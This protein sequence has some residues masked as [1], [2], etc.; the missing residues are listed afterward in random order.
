MAEHQT[1][2]MGQTYTTRFSVAEN[3][4][5]EGGKWVNGK[6]VGLDWSNVATNPWVSLWCRTRNEWI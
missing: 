5:S 3:P 2:S 4:I 6:T 1:P